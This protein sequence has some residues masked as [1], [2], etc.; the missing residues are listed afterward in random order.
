MVPNLPIFLSTRPCWPKSPKLHSRVRSPF[1]R[2]AIARGCPH[3]HILNQCVPS[4]PH[5]MSAFAV[6]W[7][8]VAPPPRLRPQVGSSTF[9]ASCRTTRPPWPQLLPHAPMDPTAVPGHGDSAAQQRVL[10]GPQVCRWHRPPVVHLD[11]THL[12]AERGMPQHQT[13]S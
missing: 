2:W 4:T 8:S 12:S 3:H 7:V 5:R 9:T 6:H 13:M 11:P 10:P 1:N